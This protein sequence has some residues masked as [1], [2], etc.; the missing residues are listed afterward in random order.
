MRVHLV[1]APSDAAFVAELVRI[2]APHRFEAWPT[3]DGADVVLLLLSR[4]ALRDG[5]GRTPADAIAAEICLLPVLLGEEVA[6]RRF[7]AH[8][9][10]MPWARDVSG[11]LRLL[12]DH[13]KN[14]SQKIADGKRE[15]FGH[16]LVLA[17]LARA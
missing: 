9:K 2:M 3:V 8:A 11:A 10:H 14:A 5:L 12:E 1:A 15:L 7:P 6:P 4:E 17:L 16:G 13:R